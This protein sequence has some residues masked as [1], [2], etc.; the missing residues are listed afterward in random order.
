MIIISYGYYRIKLLQKKIGSIQASLKSSEETLWN[1]LNNSTSI[2]YI[3][4]ISGSY[5]FINNRFEE[6]F[7]CKSSDVVY[8]N[9]EDIPGY[10][11]N[12][13]FKN[14]ELIAL[15]KG[16]A[17]EFEEVIDVDGKNIYLSSSKFPLQD[18]NG[19]V[20]AV[21]SISVNVTNKKIIEQEMN[22]YRDSL[23][24]AIIDSTYELNKTN[25]I[26]HAVL[27]TIP[28]RVYWK[29]V[30]GKYIG[31]NKL[32]LMDAKIEK[33]KN[34]IGK[35]DKD[36]PWAI[37]SDTPHEQ[38]IDIMSTGL[39]RMLKEECI[40][41]NGKNLWVEASKIPLR[42][43]GG[44]VFGLLGI[45]QD[46]SQR[47]V[48]EETLIATKEAAEKASQA[49]SMFLANMSH[50]LRTPLHGILS[51]AQFGVDKHGQVSDEKIL[52]YFQQI[53]ISG[54]RLKVLLDDLLDLSKLEAGKMVLDIQENS[55][56]DIVRA[57]IDEQ[58]A[59]TNSKDINVTQHYDENM[60]NVF[61]DKN[62]VGQMVMNIF[63]NAIKY[64]PDGGQI[65]IVCKQRYNESGQPT[66]VH[67]YITDQGPGVPEE[68]KEEIFNKFIQSSFNKHIG[69]G[70]TGLGLAIT[71]ELVFAHHGEI[72]CENN[73]DVGATFH[74]TLPNQYETQT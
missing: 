14:N 26:L 46:I 5:I 29:D 50:E 41:L 24:K 34:L 60:K 16:S 58:T 37:Y 51:Y 47:K 42:H 6:L 21:C 44:N 8:K 59:L 10:L 63:G 20:Y 56:V 33:E 65:D 36:M 3:K 67:I 62:R 25:E 71:R 69:G 38:D 53:K 23:E 17:T 27:D 49:K 57:C 30:D 22:A 40:N 48:F 12:D 54:E 35:T 73:P 18:V 64:S 74:I 2:I 52:K 28:M 31:A 1:I 4:E 11:N 45:Y 68:E 66:Y 13:T 19:N 9:I 7:S 70:G 39:S 72:W 55:I 61:C 15:D 32:F 43:S